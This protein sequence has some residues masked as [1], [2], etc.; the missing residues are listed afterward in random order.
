[1]PW[2]GTAPVG[3]QLDTTHPLAR[4][5]AG[6]WLFTE[7]GGS[8]VHDL[9]GNNN[10]GTLTNIAQSPTSGWSGGD[11]GHALRFDGT[12]DHVTIPNHSTLN[13][14]GG[15]TIC[16]WVNL[17]T[18][19]ACNGINNNAVVVGKIT[20]GTAGYMIYRDC[21][22]N[23]WSLYVYG[24]SVTNLQFAASANTLGKWVHLT[25]VYDKSANQ[26]RTYVN[27][28]SRATQAVTGSHTSSTQPLQF[29]K[30]TTDSTYLSPSRVDDIR[31][32]NRTL[33]EPEIER[34]AA[35]EVPF[36]FRKQYLISVSGTTFPSWASY[37]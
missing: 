21:T 30:Y 4:G 33:S 17:E 29:S 6:W 31:V 8:I 26:I 34:V 18:N 25:G 3:T 20:F 1:M 16:G 15:F 11:T 9:S 19:L 22:I 12:N 10:N 13:F 23:V 5:L 37:W 28:G 27:G 35:R 7:Q 14:S 36:L 32:Y 24:L 2:I